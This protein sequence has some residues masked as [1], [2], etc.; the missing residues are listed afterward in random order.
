[1]T[2]EELAFVE[3]LVSRAA[4]LRAFVLRLTDPND[5]GADPVVR[6]AALEALRTRHE[7]QQAP[8]L[9]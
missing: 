8:R 3:R 2:P 7:P 9:A 1:M 6:Q 4:E 5:L